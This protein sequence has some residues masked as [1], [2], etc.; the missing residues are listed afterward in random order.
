GGRGA[1]NGCCALPSVANVAH[2]LDK[3]KTYKGILIKVSLRS[4]AAPRS[5]R[6]STTKSS[7]PRL[8]A[9]AATHAADVHAE[10]ALWEFAP[11][12]RARTHARCCALFPAD[13]DASIAER[14]RIRWKDASRARRRRWPHRFPF[15]RRA[16]GQ[17]RA[18]AVRRARRFPQPP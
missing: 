16:R 14:S 17:R 13:S 15:P 4:A 9:K 3:R 11:E 18:A 1:G 10:R 2:A 6:D 8:P 5:L 7:A 12:L